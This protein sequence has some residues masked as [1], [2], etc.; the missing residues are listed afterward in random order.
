MKL[1]ANVILEWLGKKMDA[2][3]EGELKGLPAFGRP[4]LYERGKKLREKH[5][6]VAEEKEVSAQELLGEN[7]CV[8]LVSQERTRDFSGEFPCI[9]VLTKDSAAGVLNDVQDIFDE[10]EEWKEKL[11]FVSSGNGTLGEMLAVSL[12]IFGNPISVVGA[13]FTLKAEAGQEQVPP[14]SR[15]F[16]GD[17]SNMEYI[18]TLKQ[19][20]TYNKM[21]ESEDVFLFPAYITG[22][23]FYNQNLREKSQCKYRI[24]LLEVNHELTEGDGD[25]LAF[26]APYVKKTVYREET[27]SR[28]NSN[29]LHKIFR[30]ILTDRTADY[31]EISGQ[32]SYFGWKPDA[33]Y[34]C[35]V[36]QVTYL[37]QR[38]LTENAICSYME[39]TYEGTCSFPYGEDIVTYFNLAL[40]GMGKEELE[41]KLK[42]F[43]R[44]SFLKAGYSWVMEGHG[45]L[46][47]QYVQA[48]LALDVGG[49][50]RPYLWIHH[51]KEVA[52]SYILEQSTRR[53]PGYMICHE[54]LRELQK[55]DEQQ[56]T[57]YMKTLRIYLDE[58]LN[59][60]QSAKKLF[61]HR[62]TF[63]YR[64]EKIKAIL[65]SNLDDPEE[66]LYLSF[67]FRLLE[68]E[69]NKKG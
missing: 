68:Q 1:T 57:E 26:M 67:S 41:G 42:Y 61:I 28:N 43:I 29:S 24:I 55:C 5:F 38:N 23:R 62:S 21:Q 4:F 16:F 35:L 54:R 27:V 14:E 59:A 33:T 20:E 13:D 58:H 52:F 49:R 34:L 30:R 66:L 51:F 17:S 11:E 9:R 37:D 53:L 69:K 44:E 60:V 6:Y 64:L 47:R 65:E 10:L 2:S 31:M 32:L 22:C 45:N 25:L 46:R 7:I 36:F 63:L 39:K 50:A 56:K 18:N 15:I 19:N 40:I 12:N 48:C 3:S 8:I